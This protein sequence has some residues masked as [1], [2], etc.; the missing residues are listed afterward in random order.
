MFHKDIWT[1]HAIICVFSTQ[2]Q[3]PERIFQTHDFFFSLQENLVHIFWTRAEKNGMKLLFM[4]TFIY[5]TE[6][7][8]YTHAINL[9]VNMQLKPYMNE[10]KPIIRAKWTV[11]V[12]VWSFFLNIYDLKGY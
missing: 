11:F 10:S 6:K 3:K 8:C 1:M 4:Q 7:N 5:C 2:A 12:F 9:Y